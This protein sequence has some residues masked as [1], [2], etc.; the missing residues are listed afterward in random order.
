ME[1]NKAS[2]M[3]ITLLAVISTLFASAAFAQS[4]YTEDADIAYKRG[5][6]YEAAQAYKIAYQK[7]DGLDEKGRVLFRIGESYRLMTDNAGAEEW[8]EKAI[9]ARYY[10]KNPEV[11]FQYA[12]VLREQEKFDDAVV[13]YQK[14]QERGGDASKA[15]I[16]IDACETAAMHI[17]IP[18][19]RYLVEPVVLLNSPF[20]DYAP[21]WSSKKNDEIVFSSSRQSAVGGNEDP[22]TGESFMDLFTS[23]QDKK[24]KWSTPT[25]LNNTVNTSSNEGAS[26]MDKKRSTMY[27]TR[28]VYE[29]KSNF[30]CDLFMAKKVGNKF[31]PAEPM[32]IIDRENNDSSQVGHPALS[33]DD[34]FLLFASDMPGGKGGK[35]I[36]YMKYNKKEKSW[37]KPTNLGGSVNTSGDEMFPYIAESGAIYFASNGHVGLGGLDVFMAE[38]TGEMEFGDVSGLDYPINSSSDDFGLIIN[39]A[40]DEGYFTSS[41]PGGKGK[42]DIYSFKM[43]PLEFCYRATVYNFDTG[44]A[45]T[46]AKVTVQGTDGKS[47]DLTTDANGGISLCE[48]EVL[49]ETNFSVDVSLDGYIGTGDQFSTM[50]VTESTTFAREYFLKEIVIN[51]A[52]D[53]PLVL[54][55]FDKS[56]LLINDQVNSADS[57][58]YLYDL[59]TRNPNFV[60]QLE[61]HT[62]TRGKSE[63]NQSLS[64]RRAETCVNYLISRGIAQDRLVARGI[65]ENQPIISDKQ[66]SSMATEEEQEKAHQV[67]RR[68]IF[69]ILRFDYVPKTEETEN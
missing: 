46:N 7:V 40:K 38:S 42:D 21:T 33:P 16:K 20:F 59:M 69:K 3:R 10:K 48:G 1:I 25:P 60:V 57:L 37:G 26:C 31:G 32:N 43:P 14:Y 23:E 4:K 13:Q 53:L 55:P 47:Y 44:S 34:Q 66:I 24:G 51:K 17:D 12:E 9:E 18:P 27:F 63:Y 22:I 68:T 6:F 56:E 30:A 50:G 15:Q 39:E 8:Y 61:S 54:Y 11:Y 62:D 19:S 28:C 2:I 35:D 49:A 45:L 67:N 52:Y 41:R 64:Q 29:K 36:W 5:G 58:S 65:G